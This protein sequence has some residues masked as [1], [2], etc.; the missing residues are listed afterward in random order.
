MYGR[1]ERLTRQELYDLI[2]STPAATLSERFQLS[3]RGLGKLCERH[4]IPVPERGWWAK[5]AAGQPVQR[6]PLPEAT[7]PYMENIELWVREDWRRY[8][9]E[10]DLKWCEQRVADESTISA[11]VVPED[12]DSR[13]PL[14]VRAR[15]ERKEGEPAPLHF[16]LDVSKEARHRALRLAAAIVDGCEKRG[17]HF[18]LG[19]NSTNGA[20]GLVI[21]RQN[22]GISIEEPYTRMPHA[23]T[24]TEARE[25]AVGR[26]WSIPE[27]DS[28]RGGTLT[29]VIA[30]SADG[31]RRTFGEKPDR[32]L[33]TSFPELFRVLPK[34]A[35]HMSAD[36]NFRAQQERMRNEE[37]ERRA[38]VQRLRREEEAR[39]AAERRRRNDLIRVS[40]KLHRSVQILD[41]ISAVE[42][43]AA[44]RGIESEALVG[45]LAHARA[46]AEYLQPVD[47]ILAAFSPNQATADDGSEA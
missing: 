47:A 24:N 2:W 36:Q 17:Y 7:D 23:L 37:A 46:V 29:I 10:D 35:L 31:E 42:S 26:G 11:S 18:A 12:D 43:R 5:K 1:R 9:T 21:L 30:H 19:P 14:I 8:A 33:E 13:H 45:W 40:A 32:P 20:A 25:K 15:R 41:L 28:V 38:E 22:I 44:Q 6:T 4:R 3:G 16:A 39:M 34:I 27:F